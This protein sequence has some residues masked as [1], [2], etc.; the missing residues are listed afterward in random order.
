M[1]K[2]T[3]PPTSIESLKLRSESGLDKAQA[4]DYSLRSWLNTAHDAFEKAIT[5]WQSGRQPDGDPVDVEEAFVSFRR[6]AR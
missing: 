4:Q 5:R 3:S 6:G 1:V 2:G